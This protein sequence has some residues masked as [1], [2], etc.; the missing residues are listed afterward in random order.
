MNVKVTL[1]FIICLNDVHLR[2][3]AA[4]ILSKILEDLLHSVTD[5]SPIK[6]RWFLLASITGNLGHIVTINFL[7]RK[8][9]KIRLWR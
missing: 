6:H 3:P 9:F 8:C 1:T 2:G 7:R 4:G 5:Q